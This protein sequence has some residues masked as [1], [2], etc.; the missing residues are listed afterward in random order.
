MSQATLPAAAGASSASRPAM[1]AGRRSIRA[2]LRAWLSALL[3]VLAGCL[4][5]ANSFSGTF[6]FD[7]W[8]DLVENPRVQ[9]LWPPAWL[10]STRPLV[11]LSLAVDRAISGWR[12]AGYHATNLAIHLVAAVLLLGI[13]RRTLLGHAMRWPVSTATWCACSIATLWTVHPLQTQSVTYIIQR[14]E[15]LAGLWHL[16]ALYCL[17]RADAALRPGRWLSAC[18]ACGWLGVLCKPT[19]AIAPLTLLA[20]DRLVLASSW[21]QIFR[22]RGAMYVGLTSAWLLL[23][24]LLLIAPEDYRGTAGFGMRAAT[25]GVYWMT[26]PGVVLHYLRL[27]LWPHP[28]IL[29]YQ[30][31][32]VRQPMQALIPTSLLGLMA[33]AIGW[34]SARRRPIGWI[35]LWIALTL[36]PTSL[37]PL[38]DPAFEQR[39]YLP[40]A[41]VLSAL[42]LG[43]WTAAR[44]LIPSPRWS[45]AL[46][47]ACIALCASSL[48]VMTRRRNADYHSEVA[49]WTRT[50]MQRP[51]NAR[52]HANLAVALAETGWLDAALSQFDQA[53]ALD[54]S[55]ADWHYNRGLA[56]MRAGRFAD[57]AESCL[58]AIRLAPSDPQLHVT[59]G[60]IRRHQGQR[61]EAAAAFLRALELNPSNAQAAAN[62]RAL[63]A[64]SP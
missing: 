5:Y 40:L 58:Q 20:Y 29:D 64:N 50:I 13:I 54:P 62:L 19:A 24:G 60:V 51:E 55:R 45:R 28:L 47:L 8:S 6:V 18:V 44:Q 9:Q 36:A 53:L 39:M 3:I 15:C 59:L 32:L 37:I 14:A 12:V 23:A 16:A 41:G 63:Q 30:W 22:R 26:Q 35:G 42:V 56:L 7:D 25:A 61:D 11:E 33:A 27:A 17:I 31:P 43:G 52:A 4:A 49:I 38:A 57:A 21:R 1:P 34:A 10:R 48:I 2:R 46:S